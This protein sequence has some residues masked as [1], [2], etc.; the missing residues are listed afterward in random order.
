MKKSCQINK[1]NWLSIKGREEGRRRRERE[2][3]RESKTGP[4]KTVCLKSESILVAPEI[5]ATVQLFAKNA[6]QIVG[7]FS[8]YGEG[9]MSACV[10]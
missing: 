9:N 1:T 2:K 3:E 5:Q 8:P 6:V 4:R 7:L 10:S